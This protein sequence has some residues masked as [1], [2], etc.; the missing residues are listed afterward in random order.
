M[1]TICFLFMKGNIMAK[2]TNVYGAGSWDTTTI[3]GKEYVRYRKKYESINKVKVFYGKTQ[4]EVKQK[5]HSFEETHGYVNEDVEKIILSDYII[6]WLKSVKSTQLNI[7]L[8]HLILELCRW[9]H[10]LLKLYNN[11]LI[12]WHQNIL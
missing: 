12:I 8:S 5:I 9:E 1:M 11:I 3:N 6:T 7:I 2:K 10:Y 4:K